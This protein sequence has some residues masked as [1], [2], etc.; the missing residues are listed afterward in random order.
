MSE[1][2]EDE[3]YKLIAKRKTHILPKE[4]KSGCL[5]NSFT[6]LHL[7]RFYS[8]KTSSNVYKSLRPELIKKL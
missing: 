5:L 4:I 1:K 8:K 2:E 3:L 7:Y 6:M